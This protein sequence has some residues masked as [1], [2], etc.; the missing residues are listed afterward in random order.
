MFSF[1]SNTVTFPSKIFTTK[2]MYICVYLSTSAIVRGTSILPRLRSSFAIA[3]KELSPFWTVHVPFLFHEQ[4]IC[5]NYFNCIYIVRSSSP[6]VSLSANTMFCNV[7]G[8]FRIWGNNRRQ[9]YISSDIASILPPRAQ[10]SRGVLWRGIA[11][12]I[13]KVHV[14]IHIHVHSVH[15]SHVGYIKRIATSF[16][17]CGQARFSISH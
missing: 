5:T 6:T 2:C 9:R 7:N 1:L 3:S 17:S 12:A 11:I 14:H 16:G 13:R 4:S 10:T 8:S 15:V